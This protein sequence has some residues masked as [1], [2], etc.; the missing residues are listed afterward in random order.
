MRWQF[1]VHSD[2]R[3]VSW[4]RQWLPVAHRM[5]GAHV[6]ARGL[7]RCTVAL[8]EAVTNA[9]RHAHRHHP[10]WWIE[11]II[12]MRPHRIAMTVI[13]H[14]PAFHFPKA[15]LPRLHRTSG[16]GIFLMQSLCRRVEM[17]R[18]GQR[19]HVRMIYDETPA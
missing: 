18:R 1:A 10:E 7:W 17:V 12:E 2:V 19:N 3:A 14:G 5:S 9:I 8:T 4:L 6:T 11:L 13:D 16:R 15:Q